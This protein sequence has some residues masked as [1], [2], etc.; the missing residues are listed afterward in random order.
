MRCP[1]CRWR[2]S[3]EEP[4]FRRP[5]VIAAL[6]VAGRKDRAAEGDDLCVLRGFD[7]PHRY[8]VRGLVS[9]RLTDVDDDFCWG[10]WAEISEQAFARIGER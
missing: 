5:D 7:G 4:A 6:P 9:V 8:F 3:L 10:L 2:H 1:T